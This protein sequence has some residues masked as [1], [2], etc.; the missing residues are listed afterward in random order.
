MALNDLNNVRLGNAGLGSQPGSLRMKIADESGTALG[1]GSRLFPPGNKAAVGQFEV[2]D[3]LK[4]DEVIPFDRSVSILQ[5]DVEGFE[6]LALT[7]AI[8]TIRRCRPWLILETLPDPRWLSEHILQ[9]GYR[10]F[11]KLHDNTVFVHP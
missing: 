6:Q 2:V 3:V 1:G 5:L 4:L 11:G 9:H 10:Q 8:E 7:G